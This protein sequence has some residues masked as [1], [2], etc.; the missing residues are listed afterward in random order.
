ML[1]LCNNKSIKILVIREI[2]V[3]SGGFESFINAR[4][5]ILNMKGFQEFTLIVT[6]CNYNQLP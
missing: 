1:K 2:A 3:K 6:N 5:E 4:L